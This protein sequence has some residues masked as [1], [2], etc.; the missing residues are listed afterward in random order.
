MSNDIPIAIIGGG[1][2]GCAVAW[3]LSKTHE[4]IFLFEK[5]PGITTGENQSTRNSG[6]IHSGIY[7]D[8]KTR[9]LKAALCVEGNRMLYDF[10]ALYRVP[11]L[12]TGKLL[13]AANKKEDEV[14][15]SYLEQGRKNR[16]PGLEKIPGQKV[17]EMEPNIKAASALLVP[18]AGIIDPVSLVYRLQTLASQDGVQFLTG[19]VVTGMEVDGDRIRLD[20][21]YPDGKRDQVKAEVVINASGIDADT[22]AR[23]VNPRSPFELDPVRGESYKFYGHKRSELRLA[24]MNIYPT[25]TAVVTPNGRHFTVGVHLTP[26]FENLDYPPTLGST[27]TIGP[28]LIPAENREPSGEPSVAP[29]VFVE[30]VRPFFPWLKKDDLMWHQ[31]GLQ[32]RLKGHPDFVIT[33]DEMRPGL[34]HLLG[35]DS[36]GLTASLAIAHK[37]GNMVKEMI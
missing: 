35:I 8:Q 15:D 26:T 13:V 9:P 17:T 2:V 24:G 22:L 33:R 14:L 20:I 19:T 23:S 10:C 1:V 4:G 36:P 32:A 3:E 25:P 34:I 30:S 7:Y 5:N 29:E 21:R 12:N 31:S 11:A 18:S 27:V 6:V 37:V 16:V 28:K